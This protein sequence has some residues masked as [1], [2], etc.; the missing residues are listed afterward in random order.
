M[1]ARLLGDRFDGRGILWEMY[2]EPNIGF[3]HPKP[4]VD[5]YTKLALAVGKALHNAEPGETYVGPATSTIDFNFLE[6]CFKAGLL[7]YW[8]AVSVHPYRQKDPET[9]ATLVPDH[10]FGCKRPIIDQGYYETFNRDNVTLVDLR[11]APLREVTSTGIRTEQRS[12]D[13][14]VIVYATGFDA[15]TGALTRIDIRGRDGLSLGE[16]LEAAQD[17]PVE[18]LTLQPLMQF[19]LFPNAAFIRCPSEFAELLTGA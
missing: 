17:D 8:F 9:A 12:Y 16:F 4:N 11:R 10:P 7:E 13:L 19:Q 3:W 18:F 15:M 14:D 1:V 6:A 5:D 2:N